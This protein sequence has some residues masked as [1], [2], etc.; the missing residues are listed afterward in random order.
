[1]RYR[2][3]FMCREDDGIAVHEPD[4]VPSNDRASMPESSLKNREAL[5][6]ALS[7]VRCVA[8]LPDVRLHAMGVGGADPRLPNASTGDWN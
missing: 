3:E 2:E 4:R 5:S 7:A 1:V 8:Q 6:K